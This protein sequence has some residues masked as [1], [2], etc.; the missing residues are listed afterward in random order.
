MYQPEVVAILKCYQSHFSKS[1]SCSNRGLMVTLYVENL[2]SLL[3]IILQKTG[4]DVGS[5]I[6]QTLLLLIIRNI[7]DIIKVPSSEL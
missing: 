3:M 2:M 7:H 5:P 4:L 6:G 1:F